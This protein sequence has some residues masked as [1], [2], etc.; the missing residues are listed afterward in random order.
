MKGENEP[1][2]LWFIDQLSYEWVSW[3]GTSQV[4]TGALRCELGMRCA[5]W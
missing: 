1:E 2:K 4:G 5:D 3:E